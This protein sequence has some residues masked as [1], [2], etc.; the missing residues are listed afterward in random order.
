MTRTRIHL[1]RHGQ[2]EGFDQKRYNGQGDVALT[3]EGWQQYRRLR[4]RLA[5]VTLE[6]VYSS[7]LSRCAAGAQL[8]AEAHGLAPLLRSDLREIDIGEWEGRTWQQLQAEVPQQWQARLDDIVNYRVPG[9]ENLL[10]VADRV[11]PALQEIV[12]RHR[13]GEVL[14]VAHGGVNRI[15]L[16]S[17]IGAPLA[18]LFHVEQNFGCLNQID[19]YADGISVVSLLNG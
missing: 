2:V 6:A 17:A 5:T 16:L 7:D 10:D 8:L 4:E 1:V 18:R 9:G 11:L 15:L 12:Q 3:A 13:G 14:I 19:Y